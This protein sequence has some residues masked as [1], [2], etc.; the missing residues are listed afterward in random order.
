[1]AQIMG[2]GRGLGSL[3][4]KKAVTEAISEKNKDILA[5]D[6][7]EKILQIPTNSIEP[8]PQQPRQVFNHQDLEELIES[9]KKYGII[10]PLVVSKSGEGYQLIAGERRWRS[11]KIIGLATVPS[12][13]REASEQEKLELALIEN[14]QRRDLNPIERAI[15]YQKL[16]DEFNLN[17]E[18][19]AEKMG[20]SRSGVANTLRFLDL[21]EEVQKALADEKIT[22]GH[23]KV[24]AG[25]PTE[26]D[27][28]E[29]LNKVLQYNFTVRDAERESRQISKK[30]H[31]YRR[32]SKDV[33]VE[34]KEDL[35]RTN[36]NTKVNIKKQGEAGQ[37]VIDFYS[38]EELDSIVNRI[39]K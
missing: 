20:V 16:M 10:Q 23:A 37:I 21:P 28:L 34:E 1:M 35:L 29:F 17:Q 25:L 8:N 32:P 22:E 14:I 15:A 6:N 12:I 26:K 24:I 9:I 3:I 30:A 13:L 31:N 19:V 36:L 5:D 11:A 27:K 2:L 33:F 18:E 39:V 38:A 4:P 7:G